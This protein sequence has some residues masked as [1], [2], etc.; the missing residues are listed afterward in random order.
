VVFVL[1][2]FIGDDGVAS[3]LRGNLTEFAE[4]HGWRGF[5]MR[6][7]TEQR[8]PRWGEFASLCDASRPENRLCACC[9][10]T[11]VYSWRD[12]RIQRWTT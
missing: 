10:I 3:D 11:R 4:K 8:S 6:K 2:N 7:D 9:E 12:Y 5:V 1:S